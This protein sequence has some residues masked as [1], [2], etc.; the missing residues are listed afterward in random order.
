[1]LAPF[2]SAVVIPVFFITY[3][4]A[5]GLDLDDTSIST[6]F[7]WAFG[8]G[9]GCALIMIPTVLPYIKK[10]VEQVFNEDGTLKKVSFHPCG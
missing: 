9:G 2:P 1:M 5:S 4:G 7:A 6:A 8:L 3:K 10:K